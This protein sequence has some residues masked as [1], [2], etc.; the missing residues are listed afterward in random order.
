MTEY[1]GAPLAPL[2]WAGGGSV[3]GC[4]WV[5]FG[6]ALWVEPEVLDSFYMFGVMA[7]VVSSACPSS[8]APLFHEPPPL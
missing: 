8:Y 5:G 7:A 6:L 1:V 3:L 4:A 2:T